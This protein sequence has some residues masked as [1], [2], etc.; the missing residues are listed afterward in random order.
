[1]RRVVA[2]KGSNGRVIKNKISSILIVDDSTEVC[3]SVG[4][5]LDI[6][7]FDV[8]TA[9]SKKDAVSM[10]NSRVYDLVI[11][12]V[13]MP[14]HIEGIE[15]AQD[16]LRE[17]PSARILTHTGFDNLN[18]AISEIDMRKLD[19]C[20]VL[21]KGGDSEEILMAIREIEQSGYS[22]ITEK[23]DK[24]IGDFFSSIEAARKTY[25]E[26]IEK[27]IEKPFQ[28]LCSYVGA[29]A[30]IIFTMNPSTFEVDIVVSNKIP[31][32]N[33]LDVK[34]KL[35]YSPVKD[36]LLDEECMS[37]D[38]TENSQGKFRYLRPITSYPENRFIMNSCMGVPLHVSGGLKYGVFLFHSKRDAFN[39]HEI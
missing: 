7:G 12:D 29:D 10:Y 6:N 18:I 22:G 15:A 8:D 5:Y 13:S 4:D 11:L 19:I 35:R 24:G 14:S 23:S 33:F 9:S 20:G 30:G 21:L 16:I 37:E 26:P 2:V 1:M 28:I 25:D 3:D 38:N 34:H 36:V 31:L 27:I 32:N 39:R 17:H